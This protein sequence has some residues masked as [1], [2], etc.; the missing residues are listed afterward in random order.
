[1]KILVEINVIENEIIDL[2]RYLLLYFT[3]LSAGELRENVKT[4]SDVFS[5]LK[6]TGVEI[7]LIINNFIS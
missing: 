7:L 6:I 1:M 3:L 4:F 5:F 2:M